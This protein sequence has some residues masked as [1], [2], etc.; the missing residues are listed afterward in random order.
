MEGIVVTGRGV[1]SSLGADPDTFWD[2]LQAGRSGLRA[3]P[4]ERCAAIGDIPGFSAEPWLTPRESRKLDR[5]AELALVAALQA[6]QEAGLPEGADPAR[7]ATVIGTGI[8]GLQTLEAGTR[9]LDRGGAR[10]VSPNF[11]P[12]L[13]PNAAS[14][15]VA[16]KLGVHGPSFSVASAC[17]TGAQ[18]IGEAAR[19]LARGDADVALAGGSEAVITGLALAAFARMGALS[20]SGVS[21]PFDLER[22]GFV[23]GEGAA[24]LVLERE[25]HAHARGAQVLGR[26]AG[27]GAS[28]DAHH[29]T[30]PDPEGSGARLAMQGALDDAGL[31][32]REI[33]WISAHGTSTPFNDRIE[34]LAIGR[35]FGEQAPPVSS[36][37]SMLGHTLGAAGA[38]EALA[39]LEALRHAT[40]PPT[41]N[42][43]HADPACPLDYIPEGARPAPELRAV[44]SNAF[45]FGGQ[46]ACLAIAAA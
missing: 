30:Q 36:Q 45:G 24:V 10:E 25:A 41:A 21:R 35:V 17:A 9:D 33:G 14:G 8:G 40:L 31:A 26:I 46:N 3:D 34:S 1:V 43:V 13:M 5:Y 15:H 28:A 32:P 37:K 39:C 16:M 22:D 23:M 29:M 20:P 19:M 42:Y 2:G 27:Y 7:V 6:A 11:I 44:L 4:E 12:M 38:L 18:A